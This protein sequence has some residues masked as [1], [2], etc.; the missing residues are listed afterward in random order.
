MSFYRE[1][2]TAAEIEVYL[3]WVGDGG[4]AMYGGCTLTWAGRT[5]EER[6]IGRSSLMPQ[7]GGSAGLTDVALRAMP[8]QPADALLRYAGR[9]ASIGDIAAAIGV[10][11]NTARTLLAAAHVNFWQQRAAIL[12]RQQAMRVANDAA[13]SAS[14]P[15]G[16]NDERFSPM[17]AADVGET[18]QSARKPRQR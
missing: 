5:P 3:A 14:R 12:I 10:H 13:V 8:Q 7:D 17:P 9:G 15:V 16:G 4:G 2:E 11:R 1:Q 18:K 6:A